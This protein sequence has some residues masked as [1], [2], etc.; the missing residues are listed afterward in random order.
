MCRAFLT[1]NIPLNKVINVVVRNFLTKY[2]GKGV[3]D[4]ST[5]R[6]NYLTDCYEGTMAKIRNEVPSWQKNVGIYC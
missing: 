1:A 4:E 6:K 5:L 2:T 3:P